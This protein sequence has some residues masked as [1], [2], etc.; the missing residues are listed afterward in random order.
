MIKRSTKLLLKVA[1]VAAVSGWAVLKTPSWHSKLLE[2]KV[3]SQVVMLTNS[4][5]G[6]GTGWVLDDGDRKLTITNRHVCESGKEEGQLL[7]TAD[8]QT[9][10]LRIIKINDGAADLCALEPFPEKSGLSVTDDPSV[11][12]AINIV[13][14]PHLYPLIVSRGHVIRK[15]YIIRLP[16]AMVGD[17]RECGKNEAVFAMFGFLCLEAHTTT[18]IDAIGYPGNSGSPVVDDLGRVIGVLFAGDNT[19]HY[20]FLVPAYAVSNFI[21]SLK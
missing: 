9:V 4:T 18:F 11:G 20:S 10:V 1:L 3:G 8:N 19:T 16:Y 13:G 15:N 17:P 6:G 21:R 12:D 14:H 7:G 2:Y 5:G